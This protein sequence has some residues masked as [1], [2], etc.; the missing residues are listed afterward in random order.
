[1]VHLSTNQ[2]DLLKELKEIF[3]L[4]SSF[5]QLLDKH[6]SQ[7]SVERVFTWEEG[8]VAPGHVAVKHLF[9]QPDIFRKKVKSKSVAV[10]LKF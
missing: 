5:S 9:L 6:F 2:D 3:I 1:M 4:K 8:I 7:G 10:N